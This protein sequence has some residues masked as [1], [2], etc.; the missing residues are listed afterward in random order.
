VYKRQTKRA[1]NKAMELSVQN[2]PEFDGTTLYAIDVS[3]SMR[4]S[5]VNGQAPAAKQLAAGRLNVPIVS[6]EIASLFAGAMFKKSHN[7]DIMLFDGQ[8]EM[9]NL[10][11]D[12]TLSTICARIWER[13]R[14]G[15]TDFSLPFTRAT[16]AYDRIVI[17]SDMQGWVGYHTPDAAYKAY[18]A[19]FKCDPRIYMFDVTGHGT[20]Q[21]PENRVYTMA[22]WSDS[23]LKLMQ[24]LEQDPQA[25]VYEIEKIKL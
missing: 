11:P 15:S 13:T 20:M 18:K 17:L 5:R 4:S 8:A 19:K 12:D 7:A 2:C 25:L 3:G 14:G 16:K 21:L 6:S 24:N 23:V 9:L 1:L 22:G 10:N